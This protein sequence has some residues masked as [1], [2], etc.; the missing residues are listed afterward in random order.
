MSPI[1]NADCLLINKPSEKHGTFFLI[2]ALSIAPILKQVA[3]GPSGRRLS[4][5]RILMVAQVAISVPL[6]IGAA[7]FLRTVYNLG[8]VDPGFNPKWLLI[9]HID[10]SLNGYDADRVERLYGQLRRRL[11]AIPGVDSATVA[12]K[13]GEWHEGV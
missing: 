3:I 7:L 8:Q 11:D 5:G 6:P 2:W 1:D 10:P 9:L 13:N 12:A 4:A